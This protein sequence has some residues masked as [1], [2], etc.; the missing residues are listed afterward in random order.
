MVT[1]QSS[2]LDWKVIVELPT[3][4]LSIERGSVRDSVKPVK[5]LNLNFSEKKKGVKTII[6]RNSLEKS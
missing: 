3:D 1:C 4:S 5:I 2:E 6:Y